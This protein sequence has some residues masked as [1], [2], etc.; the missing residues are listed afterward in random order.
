MS[1]AGHSLRSAAMFMAYAMSS[2]ADS[3]PTSSVMAYSG[4]SYAI[5]LL[6]QSKILDAVLLRDADELGDGLEGQF[7]GDLGDE[8]EG[9]VGSGLRGPSATIARGAVAQARPPGRGSRAG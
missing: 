7:A 1:L 2:M 8:V 5:I 3:A 4:S 9:A 6:D